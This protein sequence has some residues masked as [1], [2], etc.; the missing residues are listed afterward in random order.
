MC[1]HGQKDKKKTLKRYLTIN[2]IDKKRVVF[3]GN[4]I[5]DFEVMSYVGF[6]VAPSDAQKQ[7]KKIAN[8]ITK[9]AGGNG[10]V[11][12]LFDMLII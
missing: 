5:N 9:S 1:L 8:M 11:R 4:D 12:E 3:V 7:I 2:N 6:S 10:V